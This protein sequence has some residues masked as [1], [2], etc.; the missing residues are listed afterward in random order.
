MLFTMASP[1]FKNF[2][3]AVAPG[4]TPPQTTD[5]TTAVKVCG[6]V[7][8]ADMADGEVMSFLCFVT[9]I[10]SDGSK[11]G[12]LILSCAVRRTSGALAELG[13]A[14]GTQINSGNVDASINDIAA[15]GA[16]V[17]GNYELDVTGHAATNVNWY[18]D[19]I[20]TKAPAKTA[21]NSQGL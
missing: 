20:A 5:A 8:L 10:K 9:G 18:A 12:V 1:G 19:V 14:G 2:Q 3:Q 17:G 15:K 4:G 21:A 7:N 6:L 11:A 16:I 13:T